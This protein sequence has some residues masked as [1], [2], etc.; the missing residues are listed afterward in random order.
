MVQPQYARA[1]PAFSPGFTPLEYHA[2]FQN[3][4]SFVEKFTSKATNNFFNFHL[5]FVSLTFADLEQNLR[6]SLIF[7]ICHI[8]N[9]R[10]GCTFYIKQNQASRG[11]YLAPQ[12]P[13]LRKIKFLDTSLC[14]KLLFLQFR[15]ALDWLACYMN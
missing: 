8:R 2:T 10:S 12:Y 9:M 1:W 13:I 7:K 11:R 4:C 14:N 5:H 3:K 6:V 15:F